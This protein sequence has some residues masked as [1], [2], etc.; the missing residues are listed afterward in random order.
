VLKII[1]Q[2]SIHQGNPEGGLVHRRILSERQ[3]KESY[4]NGVCL[5]V[6][7]SLSLG[8][9]GVGFSFYGDPEG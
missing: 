9:L 6:S 4:G 5:S 2:F 3:M 8:A 1:Q 7:L